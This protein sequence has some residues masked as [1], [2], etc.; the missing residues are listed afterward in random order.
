MTDDGIECNTNGTGWNG[1]GWETY[2]SINVKVIVAAGPIIDER[3]IKG[4]EYI[5]MG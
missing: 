4:G 1:I 2:R 5:Y 3:V